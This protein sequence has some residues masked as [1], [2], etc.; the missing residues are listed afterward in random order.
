MRY[1]NAEWSPNIIITFKN[2]GLT[3]AL[4]IAHKCSS[5]LVFIG[6]PKT[7][8]RE[9]TTRLLDLGPTQDHTTSMVIPLNMWNG[10]FKP[11]IVKRFGKFFT[12]VAH[13]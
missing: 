6:T 4:S 10:L 9:Q 8:A 1:V 3:P 2:F 11:S 7:E 5:T 12:M 13:A